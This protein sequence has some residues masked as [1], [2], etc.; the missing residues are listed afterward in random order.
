MLCEILFIHKVIFPMFTH[1]FML[2]FVQYTRVQS[3]VFQRDR[4]RF[5]NKIIFDCRERQCT[6][7]HIKSIQTIELHTST[8][9]MV[10]GVIDHIQKIC[11]SYKWYE[12]NI[13]VS[14]IHISTFQIYFNQERRNSEYTHNKHFQKKKKDFFPDLNGLPARKK[15]WHQ[16]TKS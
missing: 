8:R 9:D 2:F 4:R 10:A 13:D 15:N 12:S 11:K 1:Y 6:Y 16:Q 14:M 5:C 3:I 7:V